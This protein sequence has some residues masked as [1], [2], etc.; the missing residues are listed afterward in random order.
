MYSIK[1]IEDYKSNIKYI[2]ISKYGSDLNFLPLELTVTNIDSS[3]SGL[4]TS[5]YMDELKLKS[6]LPADELDKLTF[7]ALTELEDKFF[8]EIVT[9]KEPNDSVAFSWKYSPSDDVKVLLGNI[10]LTRYDSRDQMVYLLKSIGQ[11]IKTINSQSQ[12]LVKEHN[13]LSL[14]RDMLIKTIESQTMEKED[15]E[16]ELFSKFVCVL[17]NKKRKCQQLKS[18]IES[19]ERT[20][21]QSDSDTDASIEMNDN[22]NNYILNSKKQKVVSYFDTN[23]SDPDVPSPSQ[24][25]RKT[26]KTRPKTNT[27]TNKKK[28]IHQHVLSEDSNDSDDLLDQM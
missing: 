17:N 11:Q 23:D 18:Q 27:A 22:A 8:F 3:Y 24:C 19:S 20:K 14:E 15:L 13:D 21:I 1:E 6:L 12:Q 25:K 28:P 26:L 7:K 9:D 2:L 16:K 10:T 4:L 5:M